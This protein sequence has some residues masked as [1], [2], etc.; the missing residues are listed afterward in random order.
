MTLGLLCLSL[1]AAFEG[2][3][4]R[5]EQRPCTCVRVRS[6]VS[7]SLCPW[8]CADTST[9][10]RCH[11]PLQGIFP[12]QGSSL[13]LLGPLLCLASSLPLAPAGKHFTGKDRMGQSHDGAGL[14]RIIPR[15]EL[16][17]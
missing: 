5:P 10:A 11:S 16:G 8:S 9:E 15:D 14:N 13:R 17:P 6:V 4:G 2:R 7:C 1:D 12:T 3:Q